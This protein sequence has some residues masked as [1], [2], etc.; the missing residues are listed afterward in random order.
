LVILAAFLKRFGVPAN[1]ENGYVI[2]AQWQSALS[3]GSSAGG[4]IGLL[5]NGWAADRFGPKIVMM[6][7]L[8]ALTCFIFIM[9]S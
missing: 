1:T 4:I 9:V 2:P 7:S 8:V 5:V 3:N 6:V